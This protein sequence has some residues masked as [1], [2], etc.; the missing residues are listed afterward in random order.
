MTTLFLVMEIPKTKS[1]EGFVS[2]KENAFVVSEHMKK[3]M[4]ASRIQQVQQ[5]SREKFSNL[6]APTTDFVLDQIFSQ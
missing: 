2:D 3:V 4:A 5:Q 1:V 6:S